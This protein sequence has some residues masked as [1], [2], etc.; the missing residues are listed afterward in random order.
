GGRIPAD[1]EPAALRM[2][3]DGEQCCAVVERLPPA[4]CP[5]AVAQAEQERLD[6]GPAAAQVDGSVRDLPRERAPP[7][8]HPPPPPQPPAAPRAGARGRPRSGAPTPTSPFAG[9]IDRRTGRSHR[10]TRAGRNRTPVPER[11][12]C[13]RRKRSP[14]GRPRD[15]PARSDPAALPRAPSACR[16]PPPPRTAASMRE[17]P[18]APGSRRRKR[19]G[20]R[21]PPRKSASTTTRDVAAKGPSYVSRPGRPAGRPGLDVCFKLLL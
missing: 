9:H 11:P 10:H 13:P 6:G 20:A 16:T 2:G 15:R 18:R 17:A 21:R 3:G 7:P 14:P 8:H 19:R 4:R 5:V 12:A 1:G